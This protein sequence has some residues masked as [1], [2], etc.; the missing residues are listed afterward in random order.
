MASVKIE[1]GIFGDVVDSATAN[2]SDEALSFAI[3]AVCDACGY[4]HFVMNPKYDPKE[5]LDDGP[6]LNPN[7]DPNPMMVNPVSKAR[8]MSWMMRKW[9]EDNVRRYARK[10]AELAASAAIDAMLGSVIVDN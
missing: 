10:Q 9:V 3:E 1:I 5:T 2:M 8:Y 7:Y 6:M 4:E